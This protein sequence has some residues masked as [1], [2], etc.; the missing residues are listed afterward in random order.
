MWAR[1]S[2]LPADG[3]ALRG[4]EQTPR[5]R[6][7]VPAARAEGAPFERRAASRVQRDRCGP[8]AEAAGTRA[9][10]RSHAGRAGALGRAARGRRRS[11]STSRA[12]ADDAGGRASS[13][14]ACRSSRPRR[15]S[16]C[17]RSRCAIDWWQTDAG[18]LLARHGERES[19]VAL[20]PAG[21][22]AY[23]IVDP[24]TGERIARRR[25]GRGAGGA[26][27][28]PVL[29]AAARWTGL[30]ARAHSL[31]RPRRAQGR[32]LAAADGRGHRRCSAR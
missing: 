10:G 25:G 11:A 22:A 20:I 17:G 14:I 12:P 13:T 23:E 18:P 19:P 28:V 7:G 24:A 8:A 16:G 30:A 27:R 6:R 9:H 21:P 26:A 31:R 2:G 5:G 15:A 4:H 32:A 1:P 3:A 29:P